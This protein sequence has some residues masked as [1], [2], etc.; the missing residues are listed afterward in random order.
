MFNILENICKSQ[1]YTKEPKNY[2]IQNTVFL[3]G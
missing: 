2:I 1:N 3:H